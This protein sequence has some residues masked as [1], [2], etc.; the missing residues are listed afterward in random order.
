[1]RPRRDTVITIIGMLLGILSAMAICAFPI[2]A[3]LVPAAFALDYRIPPAGE[4][5]A[6][7]AAP[8]VMPG[9]LW[10][11]FLSMVWATKTA[12]GAKTSGPPG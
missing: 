2:W 4:I 9:G 6:I 3:F 5:V 10:A 12:D 7:I 8:Y 11:L 1:M